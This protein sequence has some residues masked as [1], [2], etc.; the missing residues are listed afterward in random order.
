MNLDEV[1]K[2]SLP[3]LQKSGVTQAGVF[4]SVA[5]GEAVEDSD[6][7]IL[8][9]MAEDKNMFDLIDLQNSLEKVLGKKVDVITYRSVHHLLRDIIF[10]EQVRIL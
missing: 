9:E 6:V 2:K 10:K 3:I 8:V 4:G 5:R 1:K 7:D